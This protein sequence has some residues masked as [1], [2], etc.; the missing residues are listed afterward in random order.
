MNVVVVGNTHR[1][2]KKDFN[3]G[4]AI[5]VGSVGLPRDCGNLATFVEIDTVNFEAKR[6]LFELPTE[7]IRKK[8]SNAHPNVLEI[9]DRRETIANFI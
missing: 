5:N 6:H 7:K 3:W 8:Y 9:L 4:S 2:Y 1:S